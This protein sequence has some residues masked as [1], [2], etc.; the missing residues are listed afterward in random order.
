[1]NARRM[2][3]VAG[4][5]AL[6][7][8]LVGLATSQAASAA[9]PNMNDA[10][11][12]SSV[13]FAASW[14][15][16]TRSLT[17]YN[18]VERPDK[19]PEA[20]KTVLAVSGTV[21]ILDTNDLIAVTTGNTRALQAFDQDGND[22]RFDPNAPALPLGR[23]WT[24]GDQPQTF[25]VELHLDPEQPYVASLSEL[26]FMIDALYGQPFA[27]VDIPWETTEDWVEL[28]PRYRI[29]IEEAD[30]TDGT[31]HLL[32]REEIADVYRRAG[33]SFDPNDGPWEEIPFYG[34]PPRDFGELDVISNVDIVDAKGNPV[35]GGGPRSMS[36]RLGNGMATVTREFTLYH[37][38]G[39]EDLRIRYTIA[40]DVYE[41]P[42]PLT[43]TEIPVPGL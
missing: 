29:H 25:S 32:V 16:A 10:L 26:H 42:I 21:Y 23:T 3:D 19:D 41:M 9:D 15:S 14:A 8:V 27:T 18:P 13:L 1:M 17:A 34:H 24:L 22:V 12:D 11:W 35:D 33:D 28:V 31:C 37:P 30:S 20:F 38:L 6:V 4:T 5:M 36:S 40:I 2:P 7:I 39:A 43:L